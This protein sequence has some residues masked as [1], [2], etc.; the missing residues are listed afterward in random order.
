MRSLIPC[1]APVVDFVRASLKAR[2]HDRELMRLTQAGAHRC[3]FCQQPI[4]LSGYRRTETS[5][6]VEEVLRCTTCE[7][8]LLLGREERA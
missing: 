6:L 1:P 4:D 5:Y 2:E 7:R 8:E 3:P